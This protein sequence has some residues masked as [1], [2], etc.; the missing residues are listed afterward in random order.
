MWPSPT[1]IYSTRPG[2][3]RPSTRGTQ[4]AYDDILEDFQSISRHAIHDGS[5]FNDKEEPM[6]ELPPMTQI[7]EASSECTPTL[8]YRVRKLWYE[9]RCSRL[10][11]MMSRINASSRG[12]ADNRNPRVCSTDFQSRVRDP[13]GG[14]VWLKVQV[15]QTQIFQELSCTDSRRFQSVPSNQ[16]EAR[17]AP[18]YVFTVNE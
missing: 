5:H 16:V 3:C 1:R 18:V 2:S 13:S 12:V 9:S 14:S 11:L 7:T 6:Y 10:R 8:E 17:L 15:H 4:H